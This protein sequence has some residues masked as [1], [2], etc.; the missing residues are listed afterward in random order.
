ML[1]LRSVLLVVSLV[2]V[3]ACG[4][5]VDHTQDDTTDAGDGGKGRIGTDGGF[6]HTDPSC[7]EAGPPA[8]IH[9]CDIAD[10]IASCHGHGGCYPV[11]IP[12]QAKCGAET[13]GTACLTAGTGGQ[14]AACGGKSSCQPGFVCLITGGDTACA[15]LCDLKAKGQCPA[16]F[17]CGPI[18]VPGFAACL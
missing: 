14:G 12:P 3:G 8:T 16:G 5:I 6:A 11:A 17:V 7:P 2:L 13:Y 10:P 9:E 4:G 1:F 18:D 15:K